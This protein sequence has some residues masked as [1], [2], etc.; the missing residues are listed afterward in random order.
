MQRFLVLLSLG[1]GLLCN[2]SAARAQASLDAQADAGV[3]PATDSVA[4]A[5]EHVEPLAPEVPQPSPATVSSP[6]SVVS[7]GEPAASP[8]TETLHVPPDIAAE[9]RA[10]LQRDPALP[11]R[12]PTQAET[13]MV[14]EGAR[15]DAWIEGLQHKERERRNGARWASTAISG[16][17]AI[18]ASVLLAID[19]PSAT[20]PRWILGS[21][22]APF[23][24][25]AALGIVL[26]G[27]KAAPWASSLWALGMSTASLSLGFDWE[28]DSKQT[29]RERQAG[30]FLSAAFATQFL[31]LIPLAILDRGLGR[32]AYAEY[33]ALPTNE[34]PRAATKLLIESDRI[35]RA[36]GGAMLLSGLV[37]MATV[38]VGAAVTDEPVVLV[39]G[40]PS[41]ANTFVALIPFLFRE[42][43]LEMFVQGE[44][45]K[46]GVF[47]F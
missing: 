47:N 44:M 4:A 45:P 46:P 1:M 35:S 18:A 6:A 14:T 22:I 2:Q 37:V 10:W 36:K 40:I 38:G 32:R 5:P 13:L 8:R 33:F 34:R 24:T 9:V 27:E 20:T 31:S 42:S 11:L 26:P 3:A 25:A 7:P 28:Q 30:I 19:D 21:S 17:M 39:G 41:L 43:R 16:G 12:V 29:Q 15:A 23:A